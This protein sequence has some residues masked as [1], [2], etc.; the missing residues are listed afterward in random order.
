MLE[1]QESQVEKECQEQ[2]PAI[3]EDLD[4]QLNEV[5]ERNLDMLKAIEKKASDVINKE[6]ELATQ[7]ETDAAEMEENLQKAKTNMKDI[8]AALAVKIVRDKLRFDKF[9][10]NKNDQLKVFRTKGGVWGIKPKEAE[11]ADKRIAELQKKIDELCPIRG[12][13]RPSPPKIEDEDEDGEIDE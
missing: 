7:L 13:R 2:I 8:K 11:E 10:R 1:N 3:K 9:L 5:R 6:K 4:N 12:S